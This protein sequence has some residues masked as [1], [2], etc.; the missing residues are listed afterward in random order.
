MSKYKIKLNGLKDLRILSSLELKKREPFVNSKK[1]LL[2]PEEGIVD[3][4]SVMNKLSEK[5]LNNFS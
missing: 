4:K 2:V 3:Y 5:I 1:T